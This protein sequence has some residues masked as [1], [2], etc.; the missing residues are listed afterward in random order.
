MNPPE[1]VFVTHKDTEQVCLSRAQNDVNARIRVDRFA[2][3][4]DLERERRL[5]ERA[6]HGSASERS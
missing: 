1:L 4:A 5:L 2:E 6:L 3:L